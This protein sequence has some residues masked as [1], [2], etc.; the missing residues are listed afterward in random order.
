M[1]SISFNGNQVLR[2]LDLVTK[3]QL[4]FIASLTINK[5]APIARRDV[6]KE[7]LADLTYVSAFTINS[8]MY[9]PPSTKNQ[10]WTNIYLRDEASNGQAP[11]DY[12]LPQIVGGKVLRTRF[13]KRFT[14]SGSGPYLLPLH[15]S[16]G[17]KLNETGRIRASQ[18]VEALYGAGMMETLR[19]N[20]Q[21]AKY[22]TLGSYVYIGPSLGQRRKNQKRNP[23][24]KGYGIYRV[25]GGNLVQVFRQ[26]DRVPTVK[27]NFQF[28][29]AVALSVKNNFES[30][31]Q[32][33]AVQAS[34]SFGRR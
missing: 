11:A 13:Q 29:Q 10:L 25:M 12:L 6:Q 32:A 34:Q 33:A 4:P 3:A 16:P 1:A 22:K 17:A 23:D 19:A 15:D 8:P 2:E 18:Y 28:R 21:G 31:F 30:V 5:L 9:G 27:P 26:L 20:R 7:M 24:I 14:S